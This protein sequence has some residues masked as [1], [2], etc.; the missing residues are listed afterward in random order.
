MRQLHRGQ[1]ALPVLL[2]VRLLA[3]L[4]KAAHEAADPLVRHA[5]DVPGVG[6]P[7]GVRRGCP[8]QHRFQGVVAPAAIT[9]Q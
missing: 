1:I 6:Q 3:H 2:A 4:G 7:A 5:E 8:D 9:T